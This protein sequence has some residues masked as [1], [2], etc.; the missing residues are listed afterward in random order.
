M[1]SISPHQYVGKLW[2]PEDVGNCPVF[3]SAVNLQ[4]FGQPMFT[5]RLVKV[6]LAVVQSANKL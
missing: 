2:A 3:Q 4:A 5:H 6:V 1:G